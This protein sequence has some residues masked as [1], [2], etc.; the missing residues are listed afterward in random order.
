MDYPDAV[1][2]AT[3]EHD[4]ALREILQEV[5]DEGEVREFL[6]DAIRSKIRR[7][8]VASRLEQTV[9]N[10]ATLPDIDAPSELPESFEE[11][12]TLVRRY[13]DL[14]KFVSSL[15]DGIWFIDSTI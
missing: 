14:S 4:S 11:E 7:D 6:S 3:G 5:H 13:I 2:E 8:F 12:P 9:E 1:V 10:T 15:Q